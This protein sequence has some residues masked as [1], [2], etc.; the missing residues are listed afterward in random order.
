MS[1]FA[2]QVGYDG[3][4][5]CGWQIQRG[6]GK[7]KSGKPAVEEKLLAA[8]EGL[9]AEEVRLVASG[10]TDAGVHASGQVAHFDLSEISCSEQNLLRGLNNLLPETIQIHQLKRAPESFRAQKSSRK[11]YSYYFQQ[12]PSRIP[13]LRNYTM[14]NR[15]TLN[16]ERMNEALQPLIGEHDFDA[17][18]STGAKV[19]S[20][21]LATGT[22]MSRIRPSAL[23]LWLRWTQ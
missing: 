11:Q 21:M 15:H 9:C 5:F 14:W 2:I 6:E 12:G 20:T 23:A 10:R 13:H 3:T 17:F 16:G 1:R 22:S 19:A 4:D 7:H 18:C 8:I